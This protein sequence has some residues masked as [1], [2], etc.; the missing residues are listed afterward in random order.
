MHYIVVINIIMLSCY[1]CATSLVLTLGGTGDNSHFENTIISFHL[2]QV[3]P[4]TFIETNDMTRIIDALSDV[5]IVIG[6]NKIN[7]CRHRTKKR[8]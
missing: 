6:N 8:Y 4:S 5:Y 2:V 3:Y 1:Y 7:I